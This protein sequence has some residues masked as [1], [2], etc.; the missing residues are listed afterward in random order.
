MDNANAFTTTYPHSLT[1]RP[2]HQRLITKNNIK[3]KINLQK[4]CYTTKSDVSP[5]LTFGSQF[6]LAFLGAG[7][8]FI[9][10]IWLANQQRV[11]ATTEALINEF[12]S[13]DM[14]KSRFVTVGISDQVKEGTI[15]LRDIAKSSLQDCPKK[16]VGVEI[17]GFT[18]HQHMSH[19]IGFY[20]KLALIFDFIKINK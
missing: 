4:E 10:A 5:W 13:R 12:S 18:E 8:A 1:S 19:V 20:R 15:D 16:F 3:P 11:S 17:D 2:Q 6:L 9:F 7:F 14:L